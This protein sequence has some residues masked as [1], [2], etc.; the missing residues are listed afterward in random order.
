MGHF[1]TRRA[2]GLKLS[3]EAIGSKEIETMQIIAH[4]EIFPISFLIG[5][6]IMSENMSEPTL[7]R[8]WHWSPTEGHNFDEAIKKTSDFIKQEIAR[9]NIY[10]ETGMNPSLL[11]PNE[12]QEGKC[13]GFP[14]TFQ[15]CT[16]NPIIPYHWAGQGCMDT[17]KLVVGND[18]KAIMIKDDVNS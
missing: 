3:I 4:Q 13:T 8:T 9:M 14:I 17:A 16:I 5:L 11:C 2:K 7:S 1:I 18:G 6:N 10:P 15:K 12:A